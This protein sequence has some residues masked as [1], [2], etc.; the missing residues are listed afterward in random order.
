[1]GASKPEEL[2]ELIKALPAD[3]KEKISKALATESKPAEAGKTEERLGVYPSDALGRKFITAEDP[4]HSPAYCEGKM[5]DIADKPHALAKVLT[6]ELWEKLKDVKTLNG[7]GIDKIIKGGIDLKPD[8]NTGKVGILAGDEES[9]YTFGELFD[10]CMDIRHGGY[11]K[12]AKHPPPELDETKLVNADKIDTKYIISTRVRC[13]RSI[14]GF[15]FPTCI[16]KGQRRELERIVVSGLVKMEGDLKGDYYPLAG[17]TSYGPKPTGIDKETEEKLIKDHFLF[18]EPDEPM[19]L[20]W[21][22]ERDWPDA[23][24]IYH[25]DEKSALVWV[26]EEDHLRIISMEKGADIVKV[27]GR[28]CRLLKGVQDAVEGEGYGYMHSEH[29]GFIT[30]CPSNCGTGLR[31]S[32][33]MTLPLL[34]KKED[35]KD[36]VAGLK[37]QARGTMGFASKDDGSGTFDISNVERLGKGESTLVQV[38]IDGIIKLIDMEKEL[39]AKAAEAAA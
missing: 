29:H 16:N 5:P 6:P 39:E 10:P 32:M 33:M 14:R 26:N 27:F 9:Y 19:L 23:R 24:G 11:P 3:Q 22:M 34:S 38:M 8:Y 12:D 18:Q 20:S 36:I 21:G 15:P 1:V 31:A 4:I 35:F 7:V 30:C 25:N 2:A 13:G 28:F 37:L 17:S